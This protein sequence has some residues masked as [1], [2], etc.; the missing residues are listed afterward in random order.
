MTK[1][2]NTGQAGNE[3]KLTTQEK[4]V[5]EEVRRRIKTFKNGNKSAPMIYLGYPS[6]VKT[7]IGKGILT[8]YSNELPRVLNWYNLTEKGKELI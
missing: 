4:F 5:I 7:L 2:I 6:E 3:I 8:P 1:A